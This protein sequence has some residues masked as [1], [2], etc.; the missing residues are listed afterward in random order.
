M[1]WTPFAVLLMINRDEI[2]EALRDFLTYSQ[3]KNT[4]LTPLPERA[5]PRCFENNDFV[6]RGQ[7]FAFHVKV[8]PA[9]GHAFVTVMDYLSLQVDFNTKLFRYF[10]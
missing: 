3:L 4:T 6:L 2:K 7:T 9:K 1:S 10:L 8:L 5:P